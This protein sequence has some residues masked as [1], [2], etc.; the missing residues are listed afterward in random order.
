MP[1]LDQYGSY[2]IAAFVVTV[3]LLGGYTAYVWS[4]LDGLR[5]RSA[6]DQTYVA[7]PTTAAAAPQAINQPGT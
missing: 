6:L 2:V 1:H 3:L 5:R 7:E 4:R